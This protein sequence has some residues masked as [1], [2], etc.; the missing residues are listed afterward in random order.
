MRVAVADDLQ[1]K[2][3]S[4]P[5]AGEHRVQLLPGLLPCGQAVHCVGGDALGAV[6]GGG[7]PE[8]GP[9]ADVVRGEPDS[10][11]AAAVADDQ[12]APAT[13]SSDDPTVSVLDPIGGAESES[14]VVGAGDDHI[15]DT[16]LIPIRQAHPATDRVT[17]EAMIAGLSVEFGDKFSGG[18]R[19]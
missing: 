17:A 6:D 5:S 10:E 12:V 19:A 4:G 3:V 16:G 1:I 9:I 2:V 8:A 14:T 13:Y 7:V 11:V 18:G 15:A